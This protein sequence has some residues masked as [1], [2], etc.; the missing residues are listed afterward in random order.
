MLGRRGGTEALGARTPDD[1]VVTAR[2]TSPRRIGRVNASVSQSVVESMRGSTLAGRGGGGIGVR[3]AVP[4]GTTPDG[5]AASGGGAE[6]RAVGGIEFR[7]AGGAELREA[8]GAEYRGGAAG[9]GE[10]Q[11]GTDAAL[12]R[13]GRGVPGI[14][15]G[16]HGMVSSSSVV[17]E[18][19]RSW[20]P[21]SPRPRILPL[22]GAAALDSKRMT[23]AERMSVIRPLDSVRA[24]SICAPGFGIAPIPPGAVR[25][26]VATYWAPTHFSAD[27]GIR[28]GRA[29]PFAATCELAAWTERQM[30]SASSRRVHVSVCAV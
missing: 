28:V 16:S 3:H 5:R 27:V 18:S 21:L 8:G 15:G 17:D 13:E 12:R 25:S 14:V 10:F 9:G 7:E 23:G 30:P 22:A 1:G 4:A 11:W 20:T 19:G 2:G 24:K 29:P 26:S 6:L